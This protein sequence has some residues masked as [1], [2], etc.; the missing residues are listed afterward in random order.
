MT[1]GSFFG[2][3]PTFLQT[4]ELYYEKNYCTIGCTIDC[5]TDVFTDR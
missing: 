5:V 1:E 4:Q 2:D 3:Y